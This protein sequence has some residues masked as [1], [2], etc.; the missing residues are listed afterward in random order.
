[1]YLHCKTIV[2]QF[3]LKH[4]KSFEYII[5]LYPMEMLRAQ[6]IKLLVF[7]FLEMIIRRTEISL[8]PNTV[9]ISRHI[10]ARIWCIHNEEND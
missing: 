6:I 8:Q 1:M 9:A 4:C 7:L 2:F 5:A 3:F 10:F